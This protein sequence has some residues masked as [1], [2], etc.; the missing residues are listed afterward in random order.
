MYNPVAVPFQR[1]KS[2]VENKED[3]TEEIEREREKENIREERE[4]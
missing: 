2:R 4:R 1:R 3:K